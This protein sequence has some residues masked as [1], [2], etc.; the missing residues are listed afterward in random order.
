MPRQ[1]CRQHRKSEFECR[2]LLVASASP[3]AADPLAASPQG[4]EVTQSGHSSCCKRYTDGIVCYGRPGGGAGW[5]R[6]LSNK[7]MH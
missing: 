7:G 2:F 3:L 5:R 4:L 1:Q 6:I